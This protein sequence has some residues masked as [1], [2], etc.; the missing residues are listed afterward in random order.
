MLSQVINSVIMDDVMLGDHAHIQNTIV[1][2]GAVIYDRC[3]LR[4]CQ[5]CFTSL[6]PYSCYPCVLLMTLGL[7]V[8]PGQN[9]LHGARNSVAW[10]AFLCHSTTRMLRLHH[11]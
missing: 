9:L 3:S 2:R 4:D 1:C 10:Q 7:C 5:V 11:A 6:C 8:L